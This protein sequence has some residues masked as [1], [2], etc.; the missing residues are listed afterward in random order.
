MQSQWYPKGFPLITGGNNL[1]Q[2]YDLIIGLDDVLGNFIG[3]S[4]RSDVHG[5]W[6]HI[7]HSTTYYEWRRCTGMPYYYTY[8][9]DYWALMEDGNETP[10]R[11]TLRDPRGK[12]EPTIA[13]IPE[14]LD[15]NSYS[16]RN[17]ENIENMGM[18]PGEKQL[19]EMQLSKK[20][21]LP[22]YCLTPNLSR[23][24]QREKS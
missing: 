15:T 18:Q 23:K 3:I 5:Q 12:A 10:Y 9:N 21:Y 20:I 4:S 2:R 22:E 16:V 14:E 17:I 7:K 24:T 11:S 1:I 6:R 8:I 13:A 19:G